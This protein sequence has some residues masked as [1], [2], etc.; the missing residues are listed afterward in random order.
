MDGTFV[1]ADLFGGRGL[2]GGLNFAFAPAWARAPSALTPAFFVFFGRVIRS[3][4]ELITEIAELW[5][6]SKLPLWQQ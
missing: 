2:V 4:V 1:N 5:I 3:R 6:R